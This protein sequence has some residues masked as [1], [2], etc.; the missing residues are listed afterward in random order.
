[1][2][3]NEITNA[4]PDVMKWFRS[5]AEV[6]RSNTAPLTIS[7]YI[8]ELERGSPQADQVAL[9]LY[10]DADEEFHLPIE[11]KF[12]EELE[13]TGFKIT[14]V[15]KIPTSLRATIKQST[16]T[17]SL[18]DYAHRGGRLLFQNCRGVSSDEIVQFMAAYNGSYFSF[19]IRS[20]DSTWDDFGYWMV[21]DK[22]QL[23][24]WTKTGTNQP[25]NRKFNDVF[26]LQEWIVEN[27][28]DQRLDDLN[29]DI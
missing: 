1:M 23:Q 29:L 8:L 19:E 17:G 28:I 21:K 3:L 7:D 4:G 10:G 14:D 27:D 26:E 15:S 2:K 6:M 5:H 13:I 24:T 16:I 9:T 22:G 12:A 25:V 11:I 20:D 18:D